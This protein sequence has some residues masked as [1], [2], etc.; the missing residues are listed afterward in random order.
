MSATDLDAAG[1]VTATGIAA[2][3]DDSRWVAG[4]CRV[5]DV[6]LSVPLIV[7]LAPVLALIAVMIRLD[8]PGRVIFRQQRLGRDLRAFT[9]LKFRSMRTDA[10]DARH[11]EYVVGLIHGTV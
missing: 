5:L 1:Q 8:S 11:R 10:E 2:T 7:L 9:M 4:S 6:V 3:G